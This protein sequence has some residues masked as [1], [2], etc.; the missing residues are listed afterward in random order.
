MSENISVPNVELSGRQLTADEKTEFVRQLAEKNQQLER[1]AGTGTLEEAR[2][3][4]E[5][6]KF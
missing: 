2:L 6:Q 4:L 5:S 1:C 3:G